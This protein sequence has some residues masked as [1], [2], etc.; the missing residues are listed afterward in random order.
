M[1]PT[2]S[3]LARG[4]ALMVLAAVGAGLPDLVVAQTNPLVGTWN[5]VPEKSTGPARYK[6]M[7]M[8]ITG[9]GDMVDVD[10]V[11][12]SGKPVKQN[13]T[14][15]ADGKP[16]P[17][18]SIPDVDTATWTRYSD[19]N[20]SYQYN[21]GKNIVVLGARSVSADKK[22]LTLREQLYDRNGKQ[23][24]TSILVFDNPD[25]QVASVTPAQA[26]PVIIQPPG[27]TADEKAGQAALEAKNADEAI[28]AFTRSLE[29]KE[30]GSD[31]HY[32]Y[33]MRGVAY[34]MKNDTA[35][36]MAD[37][38]EAVKLKD[39]DADVRFRRGA[40]RFQQKDYK[41]VV[42]DMSVVIK[43]DDKNGPA[44]RMRGFSLNML[45]QRTEGAADNDKACELSKDLCP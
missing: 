34:G 17:I 31:A 37:Y 15:V 27:L 39:D 45:D 5:L 8:K 38:D 7:T 3:A 22:T 21:K 12:A 26:A 36:A 29:K 43:A 41:G 23:L 11:D 32:D 10:G 35:K 30:K 33:V 18:A 19:T 40:I 44:Y 16:H 28:A 42:E 25:V 14:V 20:T 4:A 9:M 24:G 2:R 6:S 13:Y 1:N